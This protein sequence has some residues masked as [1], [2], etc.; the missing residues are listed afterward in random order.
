MRLTIL[1][2]NDTLIEKYYLAE[3]AVCFHINDKGKNILLDVGYSGIFISNA[4][5][6]GINLMNLDY[7]VLSHGHL[8]HTWGLEPLMKL[9]G[10]TGSKKR[11]QG[12]PV[13]VGHPLVLKPK[14]DGDEKIGTLVSETKLRDCFEVKLS[15]EPVWL[16]DNLVFLGEIERTTKFEA[17]N[18]LGKFILE[19]KEEDDMLTDD[20]ALVYKSKDGLVVITGCSHSGICNIIEYAKKVCKDDRIAD[21]VGGFHLL[22]PSKEQ[23]NETVNYFKKI[24]PS[25]VHACHCTG[26]DA[27]VALASVANLKEVGVGLVLDYD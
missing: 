21:V 2:D 3:P 12:N 16:T 26:L 25:V 4:D 24:Q 10:K 22:Q 6:M 5:K 20:S 18:P 13:I 9:Y 15:K 1:V 14:I 17:R 7:V 23:L 11:V 19:G 27:T 8:D